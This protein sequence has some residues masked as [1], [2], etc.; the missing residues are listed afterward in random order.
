VAGVSSQARSRR[1]RQRENPSSPLQL[2][3]N[4]AARG[5]AEVSVSPGDAVVEGEN[6]QGRGDSSLLQEWSCGASSA[7]MFFSVRPE[8][9]GFLVPS[10]VHPGASSTSQKGVE[11]FEAGSPLSLESNCPDYSVLLC[12]NEVWGIDV[13]ADSFRGRYLVSRGK[14]G[15][16]IL[17]KEFLGNLVSFPL[18]HYRLKV[19]GALN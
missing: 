18:E 9:Q 3:Q 1:L 16:N 11:G 19:R 17:T 12:Q 8:W 13:P 4:P 14:L 5:C 2:T 10:S 6:L 7:K 15:L